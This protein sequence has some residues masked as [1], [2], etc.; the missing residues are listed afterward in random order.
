MNPLPVSLVPH[1]DALPAVAGLVM[2][3]FPGR[4]L[5]EAG[6]LAA[7]APHADIRLRL[8]ATSAAD[9]SPAG[10]ILTAATPAGLLALDALLGPSVQRLG[11]V[12]PAVLAPVRTR[13]S[14]A[15]TDAECRRLFPWAL[16]FLHPVL[17]LTGF[18]DEDVLCPDQLLSLPAITRE[19]WLAAVP[20]PDP[21]PPLRSLSLVNEITLTDLMEATAGDIGSR[22]REHPT[23]GEPP[24][25]DAGPPASKRSRFFR[26]IGLDKA[27]RRLDAAMRSLPHDIAARRTRELR[28]LLDRFDKDPADALRHAI[29]LAG[30]G[31]RRG[32]LSL[33]GWRLGSRDPRVDLDRQDRGP[34]DAW[35]I[36]PE[37]RAALE[38]RY[39]DAAT[40]EA[41]A[42][43]CERAAYIFGELLGDWAMAAD[44]LE[45]AGRPRDAARIFLER[46]RSPARAADCMEKAGFLSEAAALHQ[47]CGH[48]EKA[49]DLMAAIGQDDAARD[50][51]RLAARLASN[52]LERAR[53]HEQKLGDPDAALASLVAAWPHSPQ[54][55]AAFSATF[56][57]LGRLRRH[58]EAAARLADLAAS[59]S[60]R[61]PHLTDLVKALA[62]IAASYPEHGVAAMT[63]PLA[64]RLAGRFIEA[65]PASPSARP[66]LDLLPAF[67]P[68]D[69]LLARDAARFAATRLQPA[70]ALA[71]RPSSARKPSEIL[72]LDPRFRWRSLC[73][74]AGG[75]TAV[76]HA[77]RVPDT[78]AAL[79]LQRIGADGMAHA[80]SWPT[81]PADALSVSA[82]TIGDMAPLLVWHFPGSSSAAWQTPDGRIVTTPALAVTAA[83]ERDEF[84][85]LAVKETG[86]LVVDAHAP[87]GSFR[88]SEIIRPAL[89]AV[90]G[91]GWLLGAC[92]G[93]LWIAGP[94]MAWR[95]DIHRGSRRRVELQ[96]APS[97]L[98]VAPHRRGSQALMVCSRE[99][100]LV[101][102]SRHPDHVASV[103]L[104]ASAT[105]HPPVA[106][107]T[108]QGAIV[109]AD[110]M[111][112]VRYA[113]RDGRFVKEADI[114][115]PDNTTPLVD[116]APL[117]SRGWAFLAAD[118]RALVYS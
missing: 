19:T 3:P 56:A 70:A 46:L 43:R 114:V 88:R 100:L 1:R 95:I 35:A 76:G 5:E 57:L 102:P 49:G 24:R 53:L 115:V 15:L 34:F 89:P 65:D 107:F 28:R 20:G 66:L 55:S 50:L 33:P 90:H 47:E 105:P 29:P 63:G 77:P 94:D 98:V 104:W 83:A 26:A 106:C 67:A 17:G 18:G 6:R 12:A 68:A 78:S 11:F 44:M 101:E 48:H 25:S 69:R 13:L 10:A 60:R 75:L 8:L 71:L 27:V 110:A 85:V 112:G 16:H 97:T 45:R 116:A 30:S 42:G 99:V 92:G 59:P 117:G 40:R 74:T 109:I 32:P 108:H 31:N 118:G 22:R 72:T 87:D 9:R 38:R 93:E 82:L 64:F 61:L 36:D 86:S 91:P 62:G 81:L 52:P 37:T 73:V 79:V 54:A 80:V 2:S 23:P 58:E 7:A 111:G 21:Q 96:A 14:M 113:C 84:L 39:R 103:N 51:W 41:D 4:W